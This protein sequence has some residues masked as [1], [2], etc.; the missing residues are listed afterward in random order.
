MCDVN[1]MFVCFVED[2][3]CVTPMTHLC[4]VEYCIRVTPM[5]YLC[6]KLRIV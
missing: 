6:L 2:C 5:T 1:D 3:V 4:F